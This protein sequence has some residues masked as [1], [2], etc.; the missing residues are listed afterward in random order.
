MKAETIRFREQHAANIHQTVRWD[1]GKRTLAIITP[2]IRRVLAVPEAL[3]ARLPLDLGV[4]AVM[5]TH[6]VGSMILHE[7]SDWMEHNT[8]EAQ[9]AVHLLMGNDPDRVPGTNRLETT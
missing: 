8:P 6:G 4:T 5:L 2:Y 1:I 9:K 7:H 3:D